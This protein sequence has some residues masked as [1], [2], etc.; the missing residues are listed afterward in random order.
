MAL[1]FQSSFQNGN[2][3]F[4]VG[5]A[6]SFPNITE[7]GSVTL[8]KQQSCN[9]TSTAPG[10]KVFYAPNTDNLEATQLSDDPKDQVNASL[11]RGE[12]VL[13]FQY[14]GKFHAMDNVCA[15]ACQS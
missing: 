13:V 4:S 11:R 3:S 8:S 7:S 10:C 14:A 15:F 2:T 1:P 5:P 12:Q 6:S 9:N